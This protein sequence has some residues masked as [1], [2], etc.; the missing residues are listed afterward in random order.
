MLGLLY[1]GTRL[2]AG[3]HNWNLVIFDLNIENKYDNININIEGD[4]MD[5]KEILKSEFKSLYREMLTNRRK[6]PSIGGGR[7]NFGTKP[8]LEW[9]VKNK[10]YSM[11]QD[12]VKDAKA[13]GLSF[14]ELGESI[15]KRTEEPEPSNFE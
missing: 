5:M 13:L 11:L 9:Q 14:G 3:F 10:Y 8:E 1:I 2:S 7:N 6:A 15:S 4:T 12:I